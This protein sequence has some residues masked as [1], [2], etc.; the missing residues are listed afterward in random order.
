[1]E[2]VAGITA[3]FRSVRTTALVWL[4]VG[5]PVAS[6]IAAFAVFVWVITSLPEMLVTAAVLGSVQGFWF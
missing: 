4:V 1:M 5:V 6:I 2:E 3:V